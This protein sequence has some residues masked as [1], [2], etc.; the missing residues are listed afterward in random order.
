MIETVVQLK[1]PGDS[2]P[3][4]KC[5]AV[6]SHAIDKHLMFNATVQGKRVRIWLNTRATHCFA[7]ERLKDLLKLDLQPSQL[8]GVETA[9]GH[10]NQ[11]LGSAD[12]KVKF[13]DAPLYQSWDMTVSFLPQF[14]KGVDLMAGRLD[15][16]ACLPHTLDDGKCSDT[17]RLSRKSIHSSTTTRKIL[18]N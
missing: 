7:D 13:T 17:P 5:T 10:N 1:V 16:K 4:A 11:I 2:R 12:L 18:P 9:N 8:K 15:V 6:D 14:L 3:L